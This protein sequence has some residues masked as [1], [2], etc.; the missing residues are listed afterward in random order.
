MRWLLVALFTTAAAFAAGQA[1]PD[2]DGKEIV[3]GTCGSCH[4][5]DLITA[6]NSSR[7]DWSGVVDRMKGYGANLDAKQTTTLLD[8]LAKNFGPKGAAPGAPAAP[9][10]A[11][12]A[13]GQDDDA[14]GKALVNGLCSSCHG[15]DLI[16]AKQSTRGEWESIVDRMKGYG[17]NLDD[18]QLKTL[19][20]YLAKAYGPKQQAAATTAAPAAASADA[21]KAI[22]ENSCGNCHDLDLVSNRTGTQAEWQDIVDR[23]NGRGAG[24]AEKDLPVL[25][26]YLT[27]TYPPKN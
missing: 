21:G 9:A 4:G 10:G 3:S 2:G 5:V 11:P 22:L 6:K 17:A 8:Y 16:T 12:A 26:Q 18:K 7:E 1:L 15:A 13:G 24:I 20:D 14:A 25:V 23:M 27:K 19:L